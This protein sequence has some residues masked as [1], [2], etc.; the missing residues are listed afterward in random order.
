MP[1]KR[2]VRSRYHGV[3]RSPETALLYVY[4]SC[5]LPG[6]NNEA[7]FRH[8]F[9]ARSGRRR[10]HHFE[11]HMSLHCIQIFWVGQI[12]QSRESE[13]EK[14][15][16]VFKVPVAHTLMYRSLNHRHWQKS[17]PVS[18]TVFLSR[19][20]VM[21]PLY[22][23]SHPVGPGGP[24]IPCGVYHLVYHLDVLP[25]PIGAWCPT[26]PFHKLTRNGC[27]STL[28]AVAIDNYAAEKS[29]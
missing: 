10:Q 21:C 24:T 28:Q 6:K 27:R 20:R 11:T 25:Y 14:N 4:V 13:T 17:R 29:K 1:S 5:F 2:V 7:R 22:L 3:L 8:A 16:G 19:P 9:D 15:L 18:P 12:Q 23:E 26:H